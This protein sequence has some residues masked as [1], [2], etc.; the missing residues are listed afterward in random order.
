MSSK[1]YIKAV[2]TRFRNSLKKE[3]QK[4]ME[5][6]RKDIE[7]IDLNEEITNTKKCIKMLKAYREKLECQCEKYV[8]VLEDSEGE[9]VE[10][11][12]NEDYTICD[13]ATECSMVLENYLDEMESARKRGSKETATRE[14]QTKL[15][16]EAK[17]AI[18]GLSLCNKNYRI[19]VNLLQ[20]RFGK[21]QEIIDIHYH[22]LMNI[23]PPYCKTESLRLFLDTVEKHMRSLEV[24]GENIDQN[25]F[26]SMVKSKIPKDV[27]LHLEV[28]KGSGNEW[29]AKTLRQRLRDYI[30]AREHAEQSNQQEPANK[31]KQKIDFQSGNNFEIKSARPTKMFGQKPV[32]AGKHI[33]AESLISGD[34]KNSVYANKCRYCTN[35][36]WSDECTKYKTIPE[37]KRLLKGACYKCLK[38]GHKTDKCKARKLCVH[39]GE[40][41]VHHRSLCPAKFSVHIPTRRAESAN[42][43]EELVSENNDVHHEN[44]L[45]SSGEVVLM[46]TARTEAKCPTSENS[47][48]IRLLLD[49]GSQRTYVTERL[50]EQLDLVRGEMQEIKLVTFGSNK[51]KVIKTPTTKLSLKL[52]NGKYLSITAN[53]V[54]D[55]TG[56]IER[57]AVH[58]SHSENIQHI[59]SSV[60]LADTIPTTNEYSTINLLVGN[61]YYLDVVLPQRIEIQPGLYL[62]SSKFGWLLTGRINE[63]CEEEAEKNDI[64]MLI[65]TYGTDAYRITNSNV[66]SSVDSDVPKKPDLEDFWAIE[67]IGIIDD[68]R[69]NDDETAMAKFKET[70]QFK[71]SRYQVTWPW[72]EKNPDLPVNRGLA[73]GRL[74]STA[75]R[76]QG[77]PELL[78]Q[79][80]SVIQDQLSKGVIE[81]VSGNSTNTVKH[82]LPHHAVVTPQKSTTKLRLVYDASA[83]TCDKNKSLNEC[84]YRG[85]VMLHDLCGILMRFRTHNIAIVADIEKA[86]LQVGLQPDQ[87]DATRFIW[88][89]D[90]ENPSTGGDNLQEYRFCRVPF[91]IISS[92]FILGA[93]IE[94]HLDKYDNDIANK[95]KNDIYVDNVIT[96]THTES[97][98]VELYTSSKAMF[99]DAAMNLREW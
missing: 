90:C 62:L 44:V 71:D 27:L 32:S 3:I 31:M 9:T 91:G 60:D 82:Y 61:D 74:K 96:G 88:L 57:K 49:S 38:V 75:S 28:Q 23:V 52:T 22:K 69:Q 16:G 85:P 92:P 56:T 68:P 67:S 34:S 46:Q 50:A 55:I 94:C 59:L 1:T 78:K 40:K 79:Y 93:T 36:H 65:L 70:I 58:L 30:I 6:S 86:F 37:R 35:S 45:V 15:V 42:V 51:A 48:Q 14:E 10:Q 77:R 76:M 20:E 97:E 26:V 4:G 24:L 2:R 43:S 66:F 47:R 21:K 17:A 98:G 72:K 84:L 87:R 83:K 95:L 11:I 64:G 54:P 63:P 89:K 7:E 80:D 53:I 25:M 39:C 13:E 33:S 41:D 18:S 81:K 8:G 19:A 99:H 5:L 29:S 73:L 12:L